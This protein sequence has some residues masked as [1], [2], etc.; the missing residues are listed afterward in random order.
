MTRT[1]QLLGAVSAF[2]LVAMSSTPAIAVGTTAGDTITNNVSVSFQVGGENQN[3][4]T[5]SDTFTVDRRVDVNVNFTGT[6]NT[7]VS[8]GQDRAVLAFE[9]TN[10]SNAT[11]DLDL[12]TVLTGGT[13]AAADITN[14]QIYLDSDGN[15]V[16]SAAE[17]AAGPITFL[18]E[19]LA[20]NGNGAQTVS[21]LVVTDIGVDAINDETFDVALVAN[22]HEAGTAAALG[23]EITA[24]SG[25]NTD[26]VDTVLFD[27]EG[28][29]GEDVDNDGAF[30]DEGT[31]EV[32]GALISV[33]KSSRVVSD[34]VNGIT[35]PKAIPGAVIEYCIA[36][37]NATGG[38]DA[39]NILV[40]DDLPADVTFTLGGFGIFVNGTA[41]IDDNSTPSDPS[42]DIAA[43][44][45]GTNAEGTPN[46]SY[47]A[48]GGTA[49]ADEVEGTLPTIIGGATRSL[50]FQVTIN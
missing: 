32:A 36:V 42:D 28:G 29:T 8:P 19:V 40:E 44:T 16:L 2:A 18:D 43:C 26:G 49:G 7:S 22:A 24:T 37:S 4:V 9:V 39:T 11:I 17:L 25:A 41:T 6:S 34:P 13:G 35:N 21:V 14:F 15:G 12:S 50:Y 31:Y 27:G 5:A 1:T 46:A 3:E 20:D 48:G 30:S 47:A 23:A 45:G 33:V 10:L 38:A